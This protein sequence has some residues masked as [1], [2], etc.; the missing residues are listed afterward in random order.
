MGLG[1]T[2]IGAAHPVTK[3]V[4]QQDFAVYVPYGRPINHAKGTDW[5]RTGVEPHIAVPAAEASKTAHLLAVR[6]LAEKC[7]D[8]QERGELAWAADTLAGDYTPVVLD[9]A[10]LAHCAG[11]YGARRFFVQ[12][13]ALHYG[14]TAYRETYPLVPLAENRFRLDDEVKFEFVLGQD[15]RATAVKVVYRDGRPEVFAGRTE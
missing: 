14:N 15:D 6:R 8:E 2:T 10:Q 9:E 4:V 3:E 12:N 1:E 5:E 11:E 13:G 7:Q